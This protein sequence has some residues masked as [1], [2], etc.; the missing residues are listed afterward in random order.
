MPYGVTMFMDSESENAVRSMWEKLRDENITS[1]MLDNEV[2]PHMTLA[3]YD[4]IDI[5][6]HLKR[7]R[8]F[9]KEYSPVSFSMSTVGTFLEPP[10]TL[11][12]APTVT[13]RLMNLHSSFHSLFHDLEHSLSEYSLPGRWFPHI[14][15]AL[16]LDRDTVCKAMHTVLETPIPEHSVIEEVGIGEFQFN[17]DRTYTVS[18]LHNFAL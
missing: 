17:K 13:H 11:F 9:V 7:F 5:S 2:R 12:L 3:I 10:G 1:Y 8:E 15:L 18:W 16:R 14:T 6:A 4:E